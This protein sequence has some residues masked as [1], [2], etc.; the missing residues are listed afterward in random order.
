MQDIK[1]KKMHRHGWIGRNG[2][3]HAN[4]ISIYRLGEIIAVQPITS[5]N[6]PANCLIEIPVDE[7]TRIVE[8]ILAEAKS[9]G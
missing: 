4:G 1:Y 3:G 9:E 7:A 8:A 5:R 2:G 6:Q